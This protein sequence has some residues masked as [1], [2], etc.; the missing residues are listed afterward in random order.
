MNLNAIFGGFTGNS[1][2]AMRLMDEVRTRTLWNDDLL[3]ISI[4]T[5]S[6]PD[7]HIIR[8]IQDFIIDNSPLVESSLGKNLVEQIVNFK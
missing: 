4:R 2:T 3:S 8:D 6:K 5:A 1:L 7:V